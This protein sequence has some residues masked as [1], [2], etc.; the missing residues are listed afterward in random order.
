MLGKRKHS[1]CTLKEKLE[2]LK[3][4]DNG[5]SATKLSVEFGVGKATI[6]DWKKNRAKIEQFSGTTSEKTLEQRH[7][8]TTSI[9]EKLD[10]ATFL[11]FTQER[12]KGVP[13]GGP[14]IQEKALQLNKKLNGDP[15]F[16]ASN[17]WL[18][19]WKKRHG[20]RQL[21]VTGEKL[22]ADCAAA[23]KFVDEFVD[24]IASENIS[25]QQV[26]NADESG[27]NFKALPTKSLA[28]KEELSAPGFKI[29]KE[30]LTILACSNATATHKLPLMVIGKSAKPRALKNIN[31]NS[32]PVFYRN[33]NKAW[34]NSNL[35]KEWFE[36]QFVPSVTRFNKDSTGLPNKALLFIDNAASHP[37]DAVLVKDDIKAIFLPP[38]VTSILQPMDQ[39]VLQNI[40]LHYRKMLLRTLIEEEEDSSVRDRLKKV[41]IRDVIYWAAE[42]WEKCNKT[43][44]QKSWKKLWPSLEFEKT[45]LPDAA[46]MTDLLQL[47]QQIPGCEK[48]EETCLQEWIAQDGNGHQ[49]LSD[50]D[51]VS[52]VIQNQDQDVPE[53][54][55]EED[56]STNLV[57]HADAASAFE[58]ALRYVEQHATATPTNV[59][60]MR[61][62][63][64][65]ASSSR[66]SSLR[67][68]K[69]S[70]FIQNN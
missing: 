5:E 14:L 48:A 9:Y 63:H 58:V 51:I 47:V 16:T 25:P 67:Q 45:N 10:K 64:N 42:A 1:S 12:E 22:S 32:L 55:E 40:K 34:M 11:W 7:N 2:V 38:N 23:D 31:M 50:D 36:T 70:D 15:T 61:R 37:S 66:F 27:L 33:Q 3:R 56:V 60:F 57:T 65:I 17:G 13:I 68:K 29:N 41:T 19:R 21:T 8:S 43:L 46:P 62:W 53:S 49:E 52:M 59:M 24:L 39:G 30:R 69:I 26:Y 20:V 35:F 28:S 44:I 6:S 18:D 4:L 54:D